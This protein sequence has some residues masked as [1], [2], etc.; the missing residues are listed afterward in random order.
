MWDSVSTFVVGMFEAVLPMHRQRHLTI[1]VA[2]L[3]LL[4]GLLLLSLIA[5]ADLRSN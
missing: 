3:I 2:I 4:I 1:A 5:W